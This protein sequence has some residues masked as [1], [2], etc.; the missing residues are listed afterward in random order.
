MPPIRRRKIVCTFNPDGLRSLI[1]RHCAGYAPPP[2]LKISEWADRY[3]YLPPGNAE[4]GK[5]HGDRLPYQ[6]DVLDDALDPTVIESIW[7]MARQLLKTTSLTIVCGY[8]MD[9]DPSTM[10]VVYPTLDDAKTFMKDKMVPAIDSTPRLRE[11]VVKHKSRDGA[12]TILHKRF[13]GGN[14]SSCGAN[15]PSSLR[16]RH[17]RVVLCDE[18][19]SMRANAEGDPIEQA[20]GRAETFFN[21]VKIKATTPTIKGLSRGEKLFDASDKQYWFCPCPHCG[22]MQT[23]KWSQV[24]FQF[25]TGKGP[26]DGWW[27]RGV[28]NAECG[29]ETTP[30]AVPSSALPVPHSALPV[31]SSETFYRD[32]AA[33]VYVCESEACG[34]WWSDAD[35]IDAINKGE[36]R[37]TAP[38]KG[39]RGRHLN[40]IYR[41]LGKKSA[42][43]SYLHEFAEGFLKAKAGGRWTLMV[44]TNTFLAE[45]WEEVTEKLSATVFEQ[46]R[47]NYTPEKLPAP[48]LVLTAGIDIQ[49][50]RAEIEI[51]GWGRAYESWGVKYR[52]LPGNPLQPQL[53][54]DLDEFIDNFEAVTADGRR[55]RI[56]AVCVD[57][58]FATDHVYAWCKA[59]YARR[60]WAVKGS[61]QPG[62]PLIGSI[63]RG[64]RRRC[65][66]YRLGTDTA[67]SEIYGNLRLP[68]PGPGYYHWPIGGDLGFDASYFAGLTAEEMTVQYVKGFPRRAWMLPAGRRN[69]PLDIT[70][71]NR[72]AV[73]ILQ[74]NW[75][76]LE[77]A[78]EAHRVKSGVASPSPGGEGRGEGEPRDYQI[79]PT[80]QMPAPA[81]KPRRPF[82]R[83]GGFVGGWKK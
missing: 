22:V 27:E 64:N 36:W 60:I 41:L 48:V 73:A 52:V 28:R 35:R 57:T 65:P 43:R 2:R 14:L 11:K 31:P 34:A 76:A 26:A 67:K 56:T 50:D 54:K 9:Q 25:E 83:P 38:F 80:K 19:D 82:R 30:P 51:K 55:L 1:A 77:K 45:T 62:Q 47:E 15:S 10:L 29:T 39:V 72:A 4:A 69:E 70:V 46:R 63:A 78:A 58:G 17:K 8:F 81:N 6:R 61:N 7:M 37:A 42:F 66:V 21:A 74:P 68:E 32:T 18:I 71:Y 13:P 20:D 49:A 12:N 40:G 59:R 23:L 24:K 16:Q 44:W 5:F 53:Y 79:D 75:D 33:T 3:F